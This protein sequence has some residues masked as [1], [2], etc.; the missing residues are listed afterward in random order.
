[1]SFMRNILNSLLLI[2]ILLSSVNM[3]FAASSDSL[4]CAGY[5]VDFKSDDPAF[6]LS[7]N[8][9][10]TEPQIVAMDSKNACAVVVW[11]TDKLSTSQVIFSKASENSELDILDK[12][13]KE[14]WGYRNGSMQN[15]AAQ[16]YHVMII[17]GLEK[18]ESYKMRA[19]SRPHPSAMPFT[20]AEFNFVFDDARMPSVQNDTNYLQDAN[21]T[22]HVNNNTNA[23]NDSANQTQKSGYNYY[24]QTQMAQ[25][26]NRYYA[27]TH[28]SGKFAGYD[29]N[30]MTK[31][32]SKEVV[33]T[34]ADEQQ[35]EQAVQTTLESEEEKNE[36]IVEV[37]GAANAGESLSPLWS[38]IK[39]FFKSLFGFG[40]DLKPESSEQEATDAQENKQDADNTGA[41]GEGD[42]NSQLV[43]SI[44]P[45]KTTNNPNDDD[46]S[47]GTVASTVN[48]G[49]DMVVEGMDSLAK[50]SV[51]AASSAK[52]FMERFAI[53]TLI[54]P[55]IIAVTV[56]YFAQQFLAKHYE[57]F[58]ESTIGYW[59]GAFA[60]LA[61]IFAVFKHIPLALSFLAFFLLALAWHLF[62]IAI[63]DMDEFESVES[64]DKRAVDN[65]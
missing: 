10:L 51:A 30:A 65:S 19:V 55:V 28:S 49:S 8:L 16:V 36:Q 47:T 42:D 50:S 25:N 37:I 54:I 14:N 61:I 13:E 11:N 12:T 48:T 56:L 58:K 9:K 32:N 46:S 20:S 2:A 1:M 24:S 35:D 21:T 31:D 22:K 57:W 40:G 6:I 17:N 18:G 39:E 44:S 60:G 5:T 34:V 64:I 45:V 15:N 3:V 33:D 53:L 26:I 41:T 4:S 52:S 59:M 62:N 63:A 23:Q 43:V 7:N 29:K 27:P 38:K